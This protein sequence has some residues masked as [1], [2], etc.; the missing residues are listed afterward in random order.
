MTIHHAKKLA[1]QNGW[2]APIERMENYHWALDRD[3]WKALGKGMG[4]EGDDIYLTIPM[5]A[6]AAYWHRFTD[7]I[8]AGDSIESYFEKL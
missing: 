7:H 2:V 3:F 6:Y 8:A 1:E 4:W 5:D